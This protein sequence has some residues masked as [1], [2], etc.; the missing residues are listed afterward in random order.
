VLYPQSYNHAREYAGYGLL[1]ISFVVILLENIFLGGIR[2]KFQN[3][4]FL[5]G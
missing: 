4:T 5:E 2:P 1:L 3:K